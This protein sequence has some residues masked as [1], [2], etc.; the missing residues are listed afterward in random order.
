MPPRDGSAAIQSLV[1]NRQV[2]A[3]RFDR[4]LDPPASVRGT[5]SALKTVSALAN[6]DYNVGF[7]PC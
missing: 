4:G 7:C 3:A 6:V 2:L 5:P 1:E